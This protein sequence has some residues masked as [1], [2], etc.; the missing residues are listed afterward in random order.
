MEKITTQ[1]KKFFRLEQLL[2]GV[3]ICFGCYGFSI[4]LNLLENKTRPTLLV[5]KQMVHKASYSIP[6]QLQVQGSFIAGEPLRFSIPNKSIAKGKTK[7]DF[8]NGVQS[9][10]RKAKF[11]YT[12]P[13]AGS[14]QLTY[15]I[16]GQEAASITIQIK[17]FSPQIA[18]LAMQD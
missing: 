11:I 1:S 8:G 2:L 16:K 17:P 14:Y 7:I 12:Y 6:G 18:H 9:S 3:V 13:E 15:Q 4:A 10:L 5:P